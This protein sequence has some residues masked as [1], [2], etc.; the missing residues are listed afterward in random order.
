MPS[1]AYRLR[2]IDHN[3]EY[4]YSDII[5]LASNEPVSALQVYPNPVSDKLFVEVQATQTSLIK[6]TVYDI[7]GRAVHTTETLVNKGTQRITIDTEALQTG[8][9]FVT[10][11]INGTTHTVKV[12]KQ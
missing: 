5:T 10:T 4:A 9:Y 6:L 11:N 7:T 12:V 3:G 1:L 2:I 8:V